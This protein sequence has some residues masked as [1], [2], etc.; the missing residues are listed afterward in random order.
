MEFSNTF[1]YS[2][3]VPFSEIVAENNKGTMRLF[4]KKL[5]LTLFCAWGSIAVSAQVVMKPHPGTGGISRLTIAGDSLSMN[6]LTATD[7]SQYKWITEKYAWGLGYTTVTDDHLS[8]KHTWNR[9]E[10][11]NADGSEVLYRLNEALTLTVT[12][13]KDDDDIVE[14]YCFTNHGPHQLSLSET[15]IYTPFNDNYPDAQQCIRRRTH[16]HIWTGGSGAYVNALR[17]GAFAP[18]LGLMVTE[19]AVV[20]YEIWE[21]GRKKAN[22]QTR[23]LFAMMLPEV[24]LR[25]GESYAMSWR[26]FKHGGNA[27]FCQKLLQ[28]GGVWVKSDKYVY[29]KGETSRIAL[30]SEREL[31]NCKAKL[32]GVPIEM[33]R[34]GNEYVVT[35]PLNQEGEAR[36]DFFYDGGKQTHALCLVTSDI[37]ELIDNRIDFIRTRQ[38]MNNPADPRYSAFMVYDNEGD[39]IYLNDTPNCNPVDRDE[40][41]ERIG[42]GLLMARRYLQNHNAQLKESVLRYVKFVREKLQTPE[43]VTYSSVDQKGRNRGYNYMWTAGLFFHAY[44]M[45]G[46]KQYALDGFHTLEAMYRQFGYGF[47]AIEIPAQ[48]A[49]ES[50]KKAGLTK[51]YNQ[52]LKE[53]KRSGDE[54]VKNGVNYPKHEVNFEQ[55]I[56][57]PAVHFLEQLYLITGEQKYLDEVKRQMPV[58]EA[59][60]GF[61]PSFH[62]NDIAI[63]HWDGHWFGK[64]EMFGDTFP[65]YWSAI[66]A[67]VFHLYAR[68]TGEQAFQHRAEN[69]V[70]GNLCLFTKDG[71]GSCAYLHPYRVNGVKAQFYDPYANDQDW[72]L[73]YYLTVNEPFTSESRDSCSEEEHIESTSSINTATGDVTV[74]VIPST[75]YLFIKNNLGFILENW[76][77]ISC[78]IYTFSLIAIGFAITDKVNVWNKILN[79]FII[80]SFPIIGCVFYIIIKSYKR[81]K[82]K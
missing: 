51:E 64:R 26:L 42:M 58:V 30:R 55:S 1:D 19:G 80:L 81:H 65:H 43:Y 70:R 74:K 8:L 24:V 41:A 22:S 49:L 54:F 45:T 72:A 15:G 75:K 25:P 35:T 57:A 68:I 60:N 40:G 69:I 34:E 11:I 82:A 78:I 50:L 12:R 59:F 79:I 17:M 76:N 63:R 73:Y 39:S 6:W 48:L 4:I 23:G 67:A 28:R 37:D 16:A 32:N 7:G 61:Q 20:D 46:D 31:K 62:L 38:Q 33:T 18:H 36:F 10:R 13:Q 9:P 71:R 77:A 2:K 53:F 44:Q 29:V 27:D 52:L 5:L 3:R 66:T 56:V 21:R 47:Y 14:R